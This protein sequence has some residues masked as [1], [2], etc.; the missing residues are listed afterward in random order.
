MSSA[1]HAAHLRTYSSEDRHPM[2]ASGGS[3]QVR[4][5]RSAVIFITLKPRLWPKVWASM[6]MSR[7]D[8]RANFSPAASPV[9]QESLGAGS[10][11]QAQVTCQEARHD[12]RQPTPDM[13][14]ACPHV[15][16]RQALPP[17][18]QSIQTGRVDDDIFRGSCHG[19]SN[20]GPMRGL[21]M[22]RFPILER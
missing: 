14:T 16:L 20:F 3:L 19:A 17:S 13:P 18:M 12:T 10:A 21:G 6:I 4:C 2:G 8:C 11:L 7:A 15:L 5:P 22:K 9:E 1:S